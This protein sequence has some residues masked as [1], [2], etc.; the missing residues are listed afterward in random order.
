MS[1][2]VTG[3]TAGATGSYTYS[4]LTSN[5]VYQWQVIE[6]NGALITNGP[7]WS[8]TT[9]CGT[10]TVPFV[11]NFDSYTVPAV[12]CGTV[13]DVNV[14]GV[15]WVNSTT[16]PAYNGLNNL[17]I[18]YS[19]AGVTQNDW[20]ITQGLTLTGGQS[21][22]VK[23]YYKGGSS[24]YVESLEVKWGNAP[25]AAGMTSAAIFSDVSFYKA[26]FTLGAGSFTP[27]TTGTYYVGWHCFSI[28]DQIN[29]NVDQITIEAT[30]NCPAPLTLSVSAITQSTASIGWTGVAPNVQIDYGTVGHAAGTGTNT[31]TVSDN[32]HPING[33]TSNTAYD[34]F[35][36]QDCGAGVYSSWTGPVTFRT[37]CDPSGI[38]NEN[39]DAAVVPALPNC[40][41][42]FSSYV[43]GTATTINTTSNSTP[44]CAQLY[45][46]GAVSTDNILL[47]S[48]K[49]TNLGA[50]TNELV[51]WA[52]SSSVAITTVIVGT[53]TDP[54]VGATFTPFQTATINNTAF[55]KV[56]ISFESYTGS[57]TYI[58]F[59]HPS[60]S[61]YSN[62][63]IDDVV[64]QALPPC[65]KPSAL[66]ATNIQATQATLSWVGTANAT[67]YD[68][69]W[70]STPF[71]PSGTPTLTG[72]TNPYLLTGLTAQTG[73]AY[74]VRSNCSA[75]G[76]SDWSGPKT[77]KHFLD[78][79]A[80]PMTV[81]VKTSSDGIT[82]NTV[83]SVAATGNIGPETKS[84]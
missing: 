43:G 6:K 69:E 53:M 26:N 42:K 19:A 5:S 20:Y 58:A 54:A 18:G 9:A 16:G 77:F 78:W 31:G 52:K 48:P 80:V 66:D 38:I 35:V 68:I 71:T 11:E 75:N 1:Q 51:F 60:L 65:P 47:I 23:F 83:W 37:A 17:R 55:T 46:S 44:N 29:I 22:D 27:A 76:Y 72:V 36:R 70:G 64:W 15:K 2:V 73:Y 28:G 32:P 33:L 56:T 40:W 41:N 24:S 50:G 49:L 10:A 84:L 4:N 74:Y 67:S 25:T 30:P 34:V 82:W 7:I 81:G 14:D 45:N 61:T 39:F 59:R 79:Y 13:I 63:Y 21:Y 57:N 8:F 62:V 12:G 3:G